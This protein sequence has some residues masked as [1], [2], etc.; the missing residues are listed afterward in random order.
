MFAKT[1]DYRK[2]L[3]TLCN[4]LSKF[5]QAVMPMSNYFRFEKNFK[6]LFLKI[7]SFGE[8]FVLSFFLFFL[9]F[10]LS[11][12]FSFFLS[13]FVRTKFLASQLYSVKNIIGNI[14][15]LN[16]CLKESEIEK[17]KLD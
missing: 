8:E 6:N 1:Y 3:N 4:L 12:F 15:K 17:V 10:F 13:F 5:I 11:F 7:E 16:Y 2:S 9:S 14:F